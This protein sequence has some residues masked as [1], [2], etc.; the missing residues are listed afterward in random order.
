[1]EIITLKKKLKKELLG[2]IKLITLIR[3]S[4]KAN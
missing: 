3:K 1:M 2:G 4:L